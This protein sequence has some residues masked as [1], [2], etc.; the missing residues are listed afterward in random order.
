MLTKLANAINQTTT[1]NCKALREKSVYINAKG[2]IIPCCWLDYGAM[3][4]IHPSR[5]D[6]KD[7]NVTF[8][9]LNDSSIQEVF[10]DQSFDAVKNSW[11]GDPIRECKRQCGAVD[12]FNSQFEE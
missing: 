6:M 1:I 10:S 9:S 2:Q 8:V 12:K 5:V 4:P 3:I 11:S 7:R